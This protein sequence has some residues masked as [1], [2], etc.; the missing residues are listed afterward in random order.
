MPETST[1][2]PTP[3]SH[4]FFQG[5]TLPVSITYLQQ[6]RSHLRIH[7][8]FMQITICNDLSHHQVKQ[9]IQI[10]LEKLYRQSLTKVTT[11]TL[12]LLQSHAHRHIKSIRIKK[13]R[14]RWGSASA[15]GNLNFNLNLAKLPLEVQQYVIIHEYSHL[16]QMN[17]SAKFWD[18]VG[19][20]DPEYKLHRRQL[21]HYEKTFREKHPQ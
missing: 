21:R 19:R 4:F 8:N 18:V 9:Q 20:F 6:K 5:Q 16:F 14:S 7:E 2:Q 17:H 12:Q 13:L 11:E 3:V 1:T 15:D 10:L